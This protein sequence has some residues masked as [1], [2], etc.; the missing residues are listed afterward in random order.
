LTAIQESRPVSATV[1]H[2]HTP[3]LTRVAPGLVVALVI[4]AVATALG[5]LLPIVG[6]PVFGILLGALAA[7]FVP[8]LRSARWKPGYDVASKPVLQLSI[9]VLGAGLSLRQ[10]LD[11]GGQSLPVMLGT[12][13][14]ALGGAWLLGRWL[15]VRGDTQILIGVG[16]GICGASAIAATTAVIKAK[17]AQVAYALGTIFTF[18]IAAVLLFPP[19]GHLLGMSPHSFG[20]WAGTAINDTSSVVAAAYTYGGDAGAYGLVVKLTRTLM[21]IPIVIV[22]A[23]LT[24][25]KEARRDA[26]L[27]GTV[28]GFSLRTMPWRRIVPVFLIGF[29]VAAALGSLGVIPAAWHPVLSFLGTFL[30]TTALAGIGLAMRL[31]DMRKA[32]PRPLLLGALLWV[33]VAVSS[34]GLQAL[35]GTL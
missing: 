19:I 6:G 24:A 18:N 8:G 3:W 15:G 22:L 20:L 30:I 26:V 33:A 34:L 14:V 17:Q 9:V 1:E 4:A 11:V 16:T 13:A 25:R 29:I 23:V 10:V 7:A 31:G 21:L 35:T 5:K 32:G 27:G 2:H 12:L 28:S